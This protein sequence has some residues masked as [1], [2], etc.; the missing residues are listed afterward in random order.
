[1]PVTKKKESLVLVGKQNGVTVIPAETPLTRLNYFD[2]KFLRADDLQ[3]EQNYLRHLVQLSNQAH[4]P[5]IAHGFNVSL[6]AGGDTLKIGPGL[7]IDGAGR[8]LLLPQDAS[9][10]LQELIERSEELKALASSF[11]VNRTGSFEE[12][13]LSSA[14][15]P[16]NVPRASDLYLITIAHT[17]ALCGE[18]DVYGKLC[19]EACVT[20]IDRPFRIEGVVVRAVPLLLQ[21]PLATSNAVTLDRTHLR[22]LVASAYFTD[23]RNRVAGLI[24]RSGLESP[25]WCFGAEAVGGSAV[26]LAVVAR[27][28]TSTVFL[29][30]WIARRERIDT[31]ARRYWQW[32]MQMRPWDVFLAHVLQFQCQLHDL[33]RTSPEPGGEDDPC[34]DAR[35]LIRESSDTM[36][37]V[38][39]FYEAVTRR[40]ERIVAAGGISTEELTIKGG[41]SHLSDLG[42][43][44]R[45]AKTAFFFGPRN[46][47]L[48]RGGIVELPSAGYLPV[49][50]GAAVTINQQV[51]QLLGEGVDLRFCVVRPDYV[52]HALEEAQH[53]ER[54]SLLEGLDAPE[55]KP[56]VDILVPDG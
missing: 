11:A 32:R 21:T 14:T 7:A 31:P 1:M 13:V 20:S 38:T 33:F 6:A 34:R 27:A 37:E 24:S 52:P 44:L 51:R 30:A 16:S 56:E 5:G 36:I 17:E 50:P 2:G 23:E 41:L 54:I 25:V 9:V 35:Q 48:I 29:D 10:S 46:R 53:M 49:A 40:L 22:S 47:I 4:G 19:E 26:P 45:L 15:P 42:K 55:K 3:A 43:K 28:G 12:C 39:R 8:V 18:E